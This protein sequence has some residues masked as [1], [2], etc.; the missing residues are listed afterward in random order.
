MVILDI[1]K[2]VVYEMHYDYILN[3]PE[4]VDHFDCSKYPESHTM[5]SAMN[6]K[7]LGKWKNETAK[8]DLFVNLL[9]SEQKCI[10]YQ[11]KTRKTTS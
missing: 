5:Y 9:G 8:L 1:A 2:T 10:L 11:V 4:A 7:K 3:M 6:K